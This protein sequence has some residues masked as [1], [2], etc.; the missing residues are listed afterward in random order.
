MAESGEYFGHVLVLMFLLIGVWDVLQNV[1]TNKCEMTYMWELPE[2]HKIPMEGNISKQFPSYSLYIYGEGDYMKEVMKLKLDGIPV[3]F[4]PGHG[5]SYQQARSL[6]SVLLRKAISGGFNDHFNVFTADLGEELTAFY[7]GNLG[8]QTKYIGHCIKRILSLYE[9]AQHKPTSVI[10]VGHSM[11]GV[12]ARGLFALPDF[13]QNQVKTIIMLASPVLAPVINVDRHMAQYYAKT[14]QYWLEHISKLRDVN[15]ISIGGGPR[16][17]QVSSGLTR[18][19]SNQSNYLSTSTTAVPRVHLSTDHQCIVWCKQLVMATVRYLFDIID[20][21]SHQVVGDVQQRVR[22]MEYHF[23]NHPGYGS[24]A[25]RDS[26]RKFKPSSAYTWTP[27]SDFLWSLNKEESGTGSYFTFDITHFVKQFTYHLV[28]RTDSVRE[29]WVLACK[30][31]VN[32]KCIE[33]TDLSYSSTGMMKYRIIHL[34]LRVL[35]EQGFTHVVFPASKVKEGKILGVNILSDHEISSEVGVPHVFSNLWTFGAGYKHSVAMH[36]AGNRFYYKTVLKD[37]QAIYQVFKLDFP[38]GAVLKTEIPWDKGQEDIQKTS[39]VVKLRNTPHDL[40]DNVVVH[41]YM[42]T[43]GPVDFQ[44]KV[45]YFEVLGQIVRYF[46]MML[47]VF[48]LCNVMFTY[49]Y[50]VNQ[51]QLGKPCHSLYDAH[52]ISSKPYKVQPFISLLKLFFGYQWFEL[53]WYNVGLPTPDSI[54]LETDHRMWFTMAPLILFLYGFELFSITRVMQI[55]ATKLLGKIFGGFGNFLTGPKYLYLIFHSV[56]LSVLLQVNSSFA[57]FYILLAY[58]AKLMVLH[59]VADMDKLNNTP[60]IKEDTADKG[61][62]EPMPSKNG[63]DDE[64]S[65]AEDSFDEDAKCGNEDHDKKDK[66]SKPAESSDDGEKDADKEQDSEDKAAKPMESADKE[67]HG[68]IEELEKVKKSTESSI[69]EAE[70]KGDDGKDKDVGNTD[71][72]KLKGKKEPNPTRL[73]E[74]EFSVNFIV[75]QLYLWLFIFTLPS[76]AGFVQNY[77]QVKQNF[78]IYLYYDYD[79]FLTVLK[80]KSTILR[81]LEDTRCKLR[82]KASVCDKHYYLGFETNL[83]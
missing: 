68:A 23:K 16:D 42:D 18:L 29:K 59:N 27:V 47:P 53:L 51:M 69:D 56:I 74:D 62:L 28:A 17:F 54:I 49:C 5:G 31:V 11:G 72:K 8:H 25:T 67:E 6:G 78:I 60:E 37:F 81:P 4:I 45:Q 79:V 36:G 20:P 19:S 35:Q 3:L 82:V 73:T 34:D 76:F 70:D 75:V 39:I 44:I 58:Y 13:K 1:E 15:T 80:V 52:S 71:A 41:I 43:P 66:I 33:A 65:Q 50:Q 24:V 64:V 10:L 83:L 26:P 30:Q 46:Y 55:Y 7:G 32:E 14:N 77:R 22:A 48:V 61:E 2:Y 12:I 9:Y 40:E 38:E 63:P 21:K 57:L